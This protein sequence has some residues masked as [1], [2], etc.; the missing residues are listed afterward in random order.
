MSQFR[1]K[2][3]KE[4]RD[5]LK[6][7]LEEA[8]KRQDQFDVLKQT[9]LLIEQQREKKLLMRKCRLFAI[10]LALSL[11][12]FSVLRDEVLSLC[13]IFST[14]FLHA[15]ISVRLLHAAMVT[16]GEKL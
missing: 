6:N 8:N 16:P 4:L 10:A 11:Q 2:A 1:I 9:E 15:I 3:S 13:L 5:E 7:R 12:Y 14:V